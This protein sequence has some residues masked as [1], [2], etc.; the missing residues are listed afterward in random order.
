MLIEHLSVSRGQCYELCHQQYKYKYHLKVIP[1][2]PEQVYFVYGKLVHKAAELF[3]ENKGQVDIFDLG[4]DLL[5]G[6]IFFSDTKK[7]YLLNVYND[8]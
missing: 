1:D 2:Q 7:L 4:N 6:K 8:S 3:V 5:T